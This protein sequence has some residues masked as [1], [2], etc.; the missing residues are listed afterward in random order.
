MT[1]PAPT[2]FDA[3][4]I[5]SVKTWHSVF[6]N[7]AKQCTMMWVTSNKRWPIVKNIRF[8]DWAVFNRLFKSF[9]LFPSLR[10]RFFI[11]QR[12]ASLSCLVFHANSF[13]LKNPM[14]AHWNS[15]ERY[16]PISENSALNFSLTRI[17][18]WF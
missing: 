15:I 16:H 12:F 7:G 1:I 14:F 8:V 9:V 17:H 18:E 13:P 3:I 11:L 5:H 2:T 4:A 6:D 10:N